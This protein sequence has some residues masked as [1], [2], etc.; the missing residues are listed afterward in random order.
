MKHREQNLTQAAAVLLLSTVVVKLIGA[1]FKIPLSADYALGDLGFGYFSVAYDFYVPIYTLALSG[2][3]VAIARMV[4]ESV[5]KERYGD[6]NRIFKLATK[7]LMVLGVFGFFAMCIAAVI[8][9]NSDFSGYSILAIAPSLIFCGL[10]SVYRGFFEGF[11]NMIPTAVSGVIEA[12]GKLILGLGAAIVVMKITRNPAL[13]AAAT[14]GGITLG[15]VLS[16]IYLAIKYRGFKSVLSGNSGIESGIADSVLFKNLVKISIPVAIAALSVSIISLI[17][18]LTLR[19]QL[20]ALLENNPSNAAILLEGTNYNNMALKE[21]PTLIYGIRGKA[22]TLFNLV[23]TFTTALGISAIP[24]LTE[25]FVKKS[26]IELKENTELTL[27]FTSVMGLPAGIGFMVVG[28]EI[29]RLLYGDTSYILGGRILILY[30]LA[31][32]FA[33]FMIP[34]TSLLQAAEKQN[35]A[36][37]NIMCGIAVKFVCN[38]C[39]IKIPSFNVYGSVIGTALGYF[40]IL[41]LHVTVILKTLGFIPNFKRCF[42]KPFVAAAVC[43]L[44]AF[45]TSKM[46]DFEKEAVISVALG[47]AVYLA[48][49]WIFKVITVDEL[50]K[51]VK[52][53]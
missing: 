47:G 21:I 22:Y 33:G 44:T 17:D 4:A 18:T 31:A 40:T 26:F 39:L 32:L 23:P 10:I 11:K 15:T 29:M 34:I 36:L 9:Q 27:K 19:M 30:G 49:L 51:L 38:L 13:A 43:G 20:K 24:L 5:A 14:M 52:K 35:A 50:K 42:L 16:T 7:T 45:W 2:F 1:F 37:F 12:M 53:G 46:L 8:L 48:F 41:V 28:K 3:P 25:C 6:A